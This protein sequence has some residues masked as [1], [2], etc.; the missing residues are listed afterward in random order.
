MKNQISGK[1]IYPIDGTDSRLKYCRNIPAKHFFQQCQI[2]N[3]IENPRTY[4]VNYSLFP[5][6]VKWIDKIIEFFEKITG[7]EF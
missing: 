2:K 3:P 5:F 6:W 7:K 1:H 4:K